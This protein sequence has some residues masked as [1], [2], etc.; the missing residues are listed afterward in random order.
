MIKYEW[1]WILSSEKCHTCR[2]SREYYRR[3]KMKISWSTFTRI[4]VDKNKI[5][6]I[7]MTL[8]YVVSWRF[9]NGRVF[10]DLDVSWYFKDEDQITSDVTQEDMTEMVLPVDED[11]IF[12]TM[13]VFFS[14]NIIGSDSRY[15][16]RWVYNVILNFS[17][18]FFDSEKDASRQCQT[19]WEYLTTTKEIETT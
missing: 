5:D 14:W 11:M 3:W 13:E 15:R 10:R 4:C 6:K 1:Y 12:F 16:I 9:L 8:T 19:Y 2:M 17:T 7:Q 18:L